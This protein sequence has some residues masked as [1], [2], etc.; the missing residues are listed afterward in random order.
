MHSTRLLACVAIAIAVTGCG[1]I[2]RGGM[3]SDPVADYIAHYQA[4][5]WVDFHPSP[6]VGQW[7]RYQDPTGEVWYGVVGAEGD[8][9]LVEKRQ[10]LPTDPSL[11]LATLMQVDKDGNVLKAWASGYEE[12]AGE[13]P[14]GTEVDVMAKPEP[15]EGG[16]GEAPE[17]KITWS[18]DTVAGLKA[19]KMTAEI[20]GTSSMSWFAKDAF[21]AYTMVFGHVHEKGGVVKAG[22]GDQ[23]YKELLAQGMQDGLEP[24]MTIE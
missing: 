23:V 12:G 24:S 7:A 9:W 14:V 17:A 21:F 6:E 13:K 3:A 15:T 16:G 2:P 10:P 22:S 1:L 5:Y 19:E 4:M 20:N 18:S 8:Q 11:T